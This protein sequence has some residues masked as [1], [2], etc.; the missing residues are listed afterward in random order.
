MTLSR[1]VGAFMTAPRYECV[2]ARNKIDAALKGA[3][4][5]LSVSGGVFY[6][7]CMQRMLEQAIDNGIDYAVTV[8]FDSVFR[9][10][11]VRRLLSVIDSRDDIDALTAVQC[12]RSM[13]Y[14]LFTIKGEKQVE[15]DGSPVR[16]DTA[17]FGLTVIKLARLKD[18]PK[19]W[20]WCKP[21]AD[22]RWEDDKIDDDIYFWHQW[23]EHGR[24]VWVD[25]TA[26]I[27]HLEEVIT[28]FNRET[29]EHEFVYQNEWQ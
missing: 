28:Q 5:P 2:W 16:V 8:D 4:V 7:Q 25:P 12:R 13:K 15:F 17:H 21:N 26:S 3:G 29:G 9:T 27:G 1:K 19:P 11:D 6:G 20:F 23:K 14:P 10:E 22:G 24:T 18:I